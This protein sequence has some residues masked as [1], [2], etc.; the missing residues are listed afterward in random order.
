M[1]SGDTVVEGTKS[2]IK[3]RRP[4]VQTHAQQNTPTIVEDVS[5]SPMHANPK[6]KV[7][8][9][10]QENVNRVSIDGL[11]RLYNQAATE[12]EHWVVTGNT[13]IQEVRKAKFYHHNARTNPEDCMMGVGKERTYVATEAPPN[14]SCCGVGNTSNEVLRSGQ[15]GVDCSGA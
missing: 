3:G 8:N 13:K 5:V 1:E 12:L 6:G 14:M 15:G 9:Q 2:R 10:G 4:N 7:N 11:E